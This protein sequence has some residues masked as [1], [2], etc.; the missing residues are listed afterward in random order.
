[1]KLFSVFFSRHYF[2]SFYFMII[3]EN[4]FFVSRQGL[5]KIDPTRWTDLG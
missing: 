3:T 5:L 1:M 2:H 4:V